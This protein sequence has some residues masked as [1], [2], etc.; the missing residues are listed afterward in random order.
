[1]IPTGCS[2]A[3]RFYGFDVSM[4]YALD[5]AVWILFHVISRDRSDR[6]T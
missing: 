3:I 1:M 2:S 4:D 6:R 5:N